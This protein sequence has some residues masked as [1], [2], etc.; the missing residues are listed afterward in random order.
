ML[1]CSFRITY[2]FQ[3]GE[4][5]GKRE[6]EDV[7]DVCLAAL[8]YGNA[9]FDTAEVYQAGRSEDSLAGSTWIIL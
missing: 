4:Y 2:R 5:W 3:E 6:Q 8:E 9:F 7:N 1:Q